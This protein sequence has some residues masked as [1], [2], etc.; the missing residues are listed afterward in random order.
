M[1]FEAV[2]TQLQHSP[3]VEKL[4]RLG[5]AFVVIFCVS[6]LCAVPSACIPK[7][8]IVYHLVLTR[9]SFIVMGPWLCNVI[10]DVIHVNKENLSKVDNFSIVNECGDQYT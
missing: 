5:I 4:R 3:K 2:Q 9:L 1:G 6:M 7:P 8:T 10:Y